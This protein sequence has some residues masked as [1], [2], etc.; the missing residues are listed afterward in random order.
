M[1]GLVMPKSNFSLILHCL[2]LLGDF[3][4]GLFWQGSAISEELF[5]RLSGKRF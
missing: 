4:A 2:I 5:G 1:R 3:F